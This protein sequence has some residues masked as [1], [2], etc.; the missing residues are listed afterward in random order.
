MNFRSNART[1]ALALVAFVP[2]ASLSGLA[3]AH[4]NNRQQQQQ[5]QQE[6]KREQQAQRQQQNQQ[7]HVGEWLR[8][9]KDLPP[10]QQQKALELL[11][12]FTQP[13]EVSQGF[14]RKWWRT[15]AANTAGR[16]GSR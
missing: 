13:P 14:S 3:Q 15:R 6:R 8:K 5:Q 1:I 9:Y 16:S 11:P 4:P 2:A 7:H 12:D 10:D